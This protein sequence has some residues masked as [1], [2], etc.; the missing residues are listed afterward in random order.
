M[1]Y[2]IYIYCGHGLNGNGL[3]ILSVGNGVRIVGT[4]QYY[5]AG[6]SYQV[7][8]L[9]YRQIKPNDPGNIQKLS[10]GNNPAYVLT[11]PDTFVNGKVTVDL[12]DSTVTAD[13]A[14][15]AQGTSIE[16]Q[17]LKVKEVYTTENEDSSSFG[18]MT[19]KCEADGVTVTVRTS[20]FRNADGSLVTEDT[21]LGKVIDVKGIVDSFDGEYQIKVFTQNNIIVK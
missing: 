1:Y 2:G 5:E 7:S 19:L 3:E 13:Y 18:A 8:G 21:Y 11:T 12:E 16:M 6:G 10:E 20:A 9:T 4:V 17:D 14:A 15:L